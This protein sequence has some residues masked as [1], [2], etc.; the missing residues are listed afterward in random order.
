MQSG[1]IWRKR[2]G[3]LELHQLPCYPLAGA[4]SGFLEF[5]IGT[6]CPGDYTCQNKNSTMDNATLSAALKTVVNDNDYQF[7]G[8]AMF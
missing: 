2:A 5:K 3:S 1:A 6:S 7:V 8:S 4:S